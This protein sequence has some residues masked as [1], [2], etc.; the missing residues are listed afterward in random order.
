MFFSFGSMG[1]SVIY[2]CDVSWAYSFV[3]LWIFA[4]GFY[5]GGPVVVSSIYVISPIEISCLL[6]NM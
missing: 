3:L 5:G 4:S 6:L 2:D 1:W